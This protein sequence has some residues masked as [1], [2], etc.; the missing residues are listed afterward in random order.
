M[1]RQ[2][3]LSSLPAGKR[4]HPLR[5][6]RSGKTLSSL[7]QTVSHNTKRFRFA[8]PTAQHTLGLPVGKENVGSFPAYLKGAESPETNTQL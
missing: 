7:L 3:D 5:V 1:G 2:R 4:Q 6:G 8:L